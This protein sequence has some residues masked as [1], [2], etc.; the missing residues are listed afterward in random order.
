VAD[1][2]EER[3]DRLLSTGEVAR[4]LGLNTRSVARWARNGLITPTMISPGGRY[5]WDLEDLKSQLRIMRERRS[6]G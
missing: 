5:L 6:E 4:I 3:S 2:P 1:D